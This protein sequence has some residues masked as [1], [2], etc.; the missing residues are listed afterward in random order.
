MPLASFFT[1]AL[2]AISFDEVF[3]DAFA[4]RVRVTA[5][6]QS[7]ERIRRRNRYIKKSYGKYEFLPLPLLYDYT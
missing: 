4:S 6:V 5:R 7:D 1:Q 2:Y 3:E